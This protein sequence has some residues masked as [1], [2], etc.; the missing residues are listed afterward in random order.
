M[1]SLSICDWWDVRLEI[2]RILLIMDALYQL[3]HL[4][5]HAN[6]RLT[7]LWGV[8]QDAAAGLE[9]ISSFRP[10]ILVIETP[11]DGALC[12]L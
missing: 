7:L 10:P 1:A 6:A 2:P 12:G 11:A 9:A 8:N 3:A 5:V 4:P